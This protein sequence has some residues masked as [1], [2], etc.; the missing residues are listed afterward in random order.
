MVIPALV[1][2]TQTVAEAAARNAVRRPSVSRLKAEAGMHA[3]PDTIAWHLAQRHQIRGSVSTLSRTI[4]P[5]IGVPSGGD[6]AR[7][8]PQMCGSAPT[9]LTS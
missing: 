8:D 7:D 6:G 2:E 3:G 1:V 4:D 5:P 9:R